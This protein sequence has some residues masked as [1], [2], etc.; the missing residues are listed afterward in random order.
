MY[1]W[2]IFLI[3]SNFLRFGQKKCKCKKVKFGSPRKVSKIKLFLVLF[4][5]STRIIYG[6]ALRLDYV[7]YFVGSVS[8]WINLCIGI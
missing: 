2:D 1:V 5:D 6:P 3:F 4:Q 7:S 8:Y